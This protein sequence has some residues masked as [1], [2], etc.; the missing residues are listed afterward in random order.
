MIFQ[1]ELEQTRIAKADELRSLGVN[2]YPHF[3]KKEMSISE[4]KAI[5]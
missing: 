4:F 2:P 3:L 5:F 1:N